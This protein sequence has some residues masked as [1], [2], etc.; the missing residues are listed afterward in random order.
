MEQGT[1]RRLLLGSEK[2]FLHLSFRRRYFKTFFPPPVFVLGV[3]MDKKIQALSQIG[4]VAAA[5]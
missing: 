2:K 4:V 3:V 5:E 1:A